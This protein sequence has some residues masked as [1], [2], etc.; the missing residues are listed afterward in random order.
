VTILLT[1][2]F[3]KFSDLP[4]HVETTDLGNHMQKCS[5]K[6][7][8]SILV[9]S[10]KFWWSLDLAFSGFNC[11]W[12]LQEIKKGCEGE[13]L[14][15]SKSCCM[16]V[17]CYRL[18]CLTLLLPPLQLLYGRHIEILNLC[19][20]S[21]LSILRCFGAALQK[22]TKSLNLPKSLLIAHIAETV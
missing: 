17:I 10:S 16:S 4:D 15:R 3:P 2:E 20:C 9:Q 14:Y 13:S 7:P 18:L 8:N 21:L 1:I 22:S 11:S 12:L 6:Y 19:R 5:Q